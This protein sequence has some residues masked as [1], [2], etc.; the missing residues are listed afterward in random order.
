MKL[1]LYFWVI[2]FVSG[3]WT[4]IILVNKEINASGMF[5]NTMPIEKI[6]IGIVLIVFMSILAILK[7]LDEKK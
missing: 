7:A 3:L 4:S 2:G 5:D 1:K 6:F